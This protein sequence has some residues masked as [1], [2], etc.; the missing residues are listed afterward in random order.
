MR[1]RASSVSM[2]RFT[3]VFF[4]IL[5]LTG[6]TQSAVPSQTPGSRSWVDAPLPGSTLP[7]APVEIIGH[8]NNPQGVRSYE[9]SVNGQT[10]QTNLLEPDQMGEALAYFST[11]WDPPAPGTYR[12]SIRSAGE[13]GVMGDAAE[14]TIQVG[15]LPPTS[16]STPVTPDLSFLS[17]ATPTPSLILSDPRFSSEVFYFE[18]ASCGPKELT[19]QATAGD[20]KIWSVV[21]FFR[22]ADPDSADRMPW[23][24]MA[25]DPL[26]GGVFSKTLRSESDIPG[27][28]TYLESILQVQLVATDNQG[29][30]ITRTAVFSDVQLRP[31]G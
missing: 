25:M 14:V 1:H 28:A 19:I 5:A 23:A 13:D 10:Q 2:S 20:S 6:C 8:A 12:L 26:G 31:C 24:S 27:F 4:I 7:L 29:T 22:L 9:L 18:G 30:E 17:T 11:S 15:Q 16:T 21:L 3:I